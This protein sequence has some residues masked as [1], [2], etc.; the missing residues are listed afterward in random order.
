MEI[1]WLYHHH[2]HMIQCLGV[3]MEGNIALTGVQAEI[4]TWRI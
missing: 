4:D 1:G 2:S 3:T